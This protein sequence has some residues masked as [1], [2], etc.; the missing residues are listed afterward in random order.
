LY[1]T[2]TSASLLPDVEDSRYGPKLSGLLGLQMGSFTLSFNK[3]QLL[4]A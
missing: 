1:S 4:P 2:S 3:E